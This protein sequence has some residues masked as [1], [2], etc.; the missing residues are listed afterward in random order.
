MSAMHTAQP[1]D[2]R[3][4][5]A[6]YEYARR[7]ARAIEFQTISHQDPARCDPDAFRGLHSYLAGAFPGVHAALGREVIGHHS[8]LYTW[9]G[10][11][12][13]LAPIV[14]A[15]HLDVVPVEAGTEEKWAYPPF[16]GC[17]EEGFV[18]GRGTLDDKMAVL[19]LLEAAEA[20]LATGFTPRRTVYLAFGEDEEV[21]G[22]NG[23]AQIAACFRARGVRPA[24]VLDEGLAVTD[25]II[26][27]VR[28]PVA[29]IGIAEK[30]YVS[31]ELTVEIA[32]GHSSMPP[33]GTAIGVLCAAVARL[34]RHPMPARLAGP[35]ALL[36]DCLAPEMPPAV[37]LLM[38]NR[39]VFG[40]LITRFLARTPSTAA[41]IRTTTA[42]TILAAGVK[43]N[44]LPTQARAVVNL[45]VV[46]GDTIAGVTHRV[47]RIIADSRVRVAET[48]VT[49][50]EPSPVSD[51]RLP[52]YQVL[53]RTIASVFPGVAM[54]PSLVL[55][56]TDSR[57]YAPLGGPCYR[58]SP[59][60]VR[61]DDLIRVHGTNERIAVDDY[62]RAVDFYT[63][64][65]QAPVEP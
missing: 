16:G 55:G 12:P 57:H 35:G 8:L 64:L 22:L 10:E 31:L 45:R 37:R 60:W 20:L 61:P 41:M 3:P 18:W 15:G 48:G 13:T 39:R 21:G 11:D 19:G 59:L 1:G 53:E 30:G 32:G 50:A 4:A 2:A 40:P 24:Y 23:A 52:G 49:R 33:R 17:I 9:P 14:L 46:P 27:N 47:R 43:E 7:L 34:E 62:A 54:A 56:A 29:L 5:V 6:P 51:T 26:A 42:A 28:R 63:Q 44:V 65:I 38:G 36:I 25:G 58:F